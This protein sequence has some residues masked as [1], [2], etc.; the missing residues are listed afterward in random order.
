M[1][2]TIVCLVYAALVNAECTTGVELL[3]DGKTWP[4]SETTL[5][6]SIG[7]SGG[8]VSCRKCGGSGTHYWYDSTNRRR[9]PMCNDNNRLTICNY[10]V[11]KGERGLR[12]SNFLSS[13][14][15]NYTC[16]LRRNNFTIMIDVLS[17]PTITTHPTSQLTNVSMS[18]ILDCEGTGRGSITYQWETRSINGGRWM[19]VSGGT[20]NRLVVRNLRQSRQYRCVVSNEAGN[21]TSR[22]AIVT[23]LSK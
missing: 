21:I 15:G 9:I 17:P 23:V 16:R 11:Q 20:N 14:V 22:V 5:Y 13:Q 8:F 7:S 4:S 19:N 1:C 6:K 2:I 3:V 12:F 10:R 18:V